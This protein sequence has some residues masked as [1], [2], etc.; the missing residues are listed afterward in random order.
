[1]YFLLIR[2]AGDVARRRE[3]RNKNRVLANIN[4]IRT[5]GRPKHRGKDN[6]KMDLT[7]IRFEDVSSITLARVGISDGYWNRGT[8]HSGFIK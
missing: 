6:I 3:K 1:M 8:E 5:L 4:G 7:E 2:W